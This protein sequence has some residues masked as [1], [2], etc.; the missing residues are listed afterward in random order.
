MTQRP[1]AIRAQRLRR[2]FGDLVAV[3]ELSL[4]V[5]A[6]TIFGF[7][8]PNGAGKTTT[9]RL[10][11]GLLEPTAGRAEVVG[12]DVGERGNDVRRRVGVL[13]EYSGLYERLSAYDNLE[14][15]GRLW[16]MPAPAR[17]ARIDQLLEHFGLAGR[18]DDVVGS[19]SRGMRQKLGLARALLHEPEVL[20]LDEPTAGLDPVAAAA[21]REDLER[22]VHQE[23]RTVFLTTHNLDE[24]Q[25]LC[26]GLAVIDHGRV[27]AVGPPE[28][29]RAG[30]GRPGLV[31][32]GS[33]LGEDVQTRLR[34]R[35][36]V[37]AVRGGDR[38]LV[39]E[40]HEATSAAPLVRLLVESGADIEE[41]QKSSPTLEEAFLHLLK[42]DE[43]QTEPL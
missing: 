27:L 4:E 39:I 37:A 10:L 43:R 18:G 23:E 29:I 31:V 21:L 16:H 17:R 14:F 33:G 34:A 12:L 25:R 9:I 36:E 6:G 42:A 24:A 28:Q 11:L 8:G 26:Q 38:R 32:T 15:Y 20:F 2:T 22:L 19:W 13:L 41:V 40:L 5:P 35:P 1:P 3:D 7:L 30:Q